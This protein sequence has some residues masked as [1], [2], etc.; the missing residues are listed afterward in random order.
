MT[1][2]PIEQAGPEPA[3]PGDPINARAEKVIHLANRRLK[4]AI[5]QA[6]LEAAMREAMRGKT[7]R[8]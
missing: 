6:E 7:E 2:I 5:E 1:P 8:S 4:K 3:E